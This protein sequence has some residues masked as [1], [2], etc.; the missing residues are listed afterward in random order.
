MLSRARI[1]SVVLFLAAAALLIGCSDAEPGGS[2]SSGAGNNSAGQSS[3]GAGVLADNGAGGDSTAGTGSG[4]SQSAGSSGVGTAGSAG[5]GGMS[6]GAGGMI[7]SGDGGAAGPIP[8][9][10]CGMAASQALNSWVE[11]PTLSVNAK[12]RQWWIWLPTNYNPSRAYPVVFTFHGCGGPTNFIPMQK[13]TGEDAIVVRGT[14]VDPMGC[15]TYSGTGEDVSFFDAML[16]DLEAKRCVDTSRVFLTGYSSGS[17]FTNTLE[18]VRGDKL[19]ATGTVSGGVAVKGNCKGKYARIFVH[20]A[21][22]TTNYFIRNGDTTRD[23]NYVERARLLALNHCAADTPPV[24]EAPAPCARYQ[25]CDPG[26]PVLMC[27]TTGKGH[28]RQDTLATTA[29]WG[30]FSSL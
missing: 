11:Q 30:L 25:S 5:S 28:D 8:S 12:N 19:R 22:D 6:G 3:G 26:Y 17:W 14:G 21:N 10:G 9:M 20:D 4:G 13:V 23:G 24:P 29:F 27:Q 16:A 15:W 18:C 7:T 2:G 1:R